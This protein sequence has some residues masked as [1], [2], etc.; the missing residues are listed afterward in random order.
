MYQIA[1][2]HYIKQKYPHLQVIGGNG[3]YGVTPLSPSE[4]QGDDIVPG[5]GGKGFGY[6]LGRG[7][8]IRSQDVPGQGGDTLASH[9]SLG[10]LHPQW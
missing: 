2:V 10:F 9:S 3:E 8:Y 1:M 4:L 6:H 7:R 5:E